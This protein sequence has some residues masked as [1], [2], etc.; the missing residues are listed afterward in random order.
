[1][2]RITTLLLAIAF[3]I[4]A[5]AEV[6][7]PIAVDKTPTSSVVGGQGANP[8]AEVPKCVPKLGENPY[9][10]FISF[11]YAWIAADI[12]R[13]FSEVSSHRSK[14]KHLLVSHLIL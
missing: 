13:R 8:A 5:F 6:S 9:W 1:M 3:C 14:H 4:P 11:L 2:K 10:V 7:N 12:A